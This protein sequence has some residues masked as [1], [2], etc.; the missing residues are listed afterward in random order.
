M[1]RSTFSDILT[2]ALLS[3]AKFIK[4]LKHNNVDI[5]VF[6]KTGGF[7][8]AKKDFE[9]LAPTDAINGMVCITLI[10]FRAARSKNVSPI[11]RKMRR[12]SFIPR[13]RNVSSSNFS[14]LVHFKVSNDCVSGQGRP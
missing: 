12:F 11:M 8:Q 1:S 10:T 7:T 3:G 2:E 9:T 6:V 13:M 14:L 5:R 4:R